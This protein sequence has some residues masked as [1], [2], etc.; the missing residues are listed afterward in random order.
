MEIDSQISPL[1]F[2]RFRYVVDR[3]NVEWYKLLL[4]DGYEDSEHFLINEE[5]SCLQVSGEVFEG[6]VRLDLVQVFLLLLLGSKVNVVISESL[7]E[8]FKF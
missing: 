5:L 7:L 3:T 8:L 4:I 6:F 1:T 2:T